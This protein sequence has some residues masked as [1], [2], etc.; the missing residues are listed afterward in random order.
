MLAGSISND[1]LSNDW[2]KIGNVTKHLG[3]TFELSDLGVAR[4]MNF[5]GI[6]STTLTDGAT[7]ATLTAKTTGSLSKTTGFVLG[8]VVLYGDAEFVW[9]GS[10]WEL[11]GD[12]TAYALKSD[13]VTNVAYASKKFTKTIN[14]STTDIVTIS[15]IKTDLALVKSDVGLD[16]VTNH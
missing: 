13:A 3:E 14:G 8:D 11:L 5:I 16:N 2:I 4:A 15:T 7:T 12:E 1:K 9:T 6:T 10:A